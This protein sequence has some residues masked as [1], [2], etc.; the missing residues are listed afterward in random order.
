MR[1]K[2][3]QRSI[4]KL[5][6]RAAVSPDEQQVFQNAAVLFDRRVRDLEAALAHDR[7]GASRHHRAQLLLWRAVV[8]PRCV[9]EQ[10]LP[11]RF[12]ERDLLIALPQMWLLLA[13]RRRQ[14]L[15]LFGNDERRT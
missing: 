13:C 9:C 11:E 8:A 6:L 15:R 12:G 3:A 7:K 1:V 10:I 14:Q 2:S 5:D 4:P